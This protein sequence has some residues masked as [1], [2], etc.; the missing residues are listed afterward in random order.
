MFWR[1]RAA[2]GNNNRLA[3]EFT[4]FQGDSVTNRWM[5]RKDANIADW[6]PH[7]IWPV[8]WNSISDTD[9]VRGWAALGVTA[10]ESSAWLDVVCSPP[11]ESNS[12]AVCSLFI[13]SLVTH[14]LSADYRSHFLHNFTQV[15]PAISIQDVDFSCPVYKRIA[16]SGQ[17][18]ALQFY[19]WKIGPP[20]AAGIERHEFWL[21]DACTK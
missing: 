13:L 6:N 1:V 5:R 8:N 16:E 4:D 3:W 7:P 21:H 14:V 12:D 17:R 10:T 19:G 18:V 11:I 2:G 15:L 9:W 20:V